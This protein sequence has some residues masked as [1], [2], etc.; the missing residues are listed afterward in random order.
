MARP[1]LKWAGGK[2]QLL[3]EIFTRFPPAFGQGKMRR[4]AEPFIGGGAVLFHLIE[5]D[6]IDEAYISDYNPELY[7]TYMAIQTDVDAVISELKILQNEYDSSSP[8]DRKTR[9]YGLREIFNQSRI[10]IDFE[11]YSK[12]WCVRAA[13]MIYLNKAGFNGLF[14]VNSKGGFNVPPSNLAD[15]KILDEDNL[16]DVAR[17][18]KNIN[19]I[20]GDFSECKNWV[21]K[22][23]FIYFDPPYRPLNPTS[24]TSYSTNNFNDDEQQRLAEFALDLSSKGASVMLSNSDPKNVDENDDFFEELYQTKDG[25]KISRIQAIRAI[26]SKGDGRGAISE[27]IITNY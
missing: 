10:E 17:V 16:R 27:L 12:K 14:R 5:L 11:K 18:L 6:L 3:K 2:R 7:L 23:T 21:D 13:Q 25:F 20:K 19:I 4:Y 8:D 1:F 26:N 22:N 9:Y 15:K 24:F